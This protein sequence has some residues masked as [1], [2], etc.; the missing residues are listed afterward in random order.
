MIFDREQHCGLRSV[1]VGTMIL[2]RNLLQDRKEL[3]HGH[4][5]KLTYVVVLAL[6]LSSVFTKR[7]LMKKKTN[8]DAPY[9][10]ESFKYGFFNVAFFV[11]WLVQ[12]EFV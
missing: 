10:K 2:I 3:A 11:F 6:K 1:K 7:T 12:Y 5:C 9:L 4:C 8:F